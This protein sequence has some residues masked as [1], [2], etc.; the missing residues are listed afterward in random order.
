MLDRIVYCLFKVR[1]VDGFALLLRY[2]WLMAP[3][4]SILAAESGGL[5]AGAAAA[6]CVDDTD[7]A[8]ERERAR[9]ERSWREDFR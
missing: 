3:K 4:T 9:G 6:G 1:K 8:R 5:G 2:G 7:E